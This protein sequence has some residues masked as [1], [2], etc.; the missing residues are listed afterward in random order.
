MMENT[1]LTGNTVR[2]T[3]TFKDNGGQLKDPNL[4]K[5]IFYNYRFEK[6]EEFVLG[7]ANKVSI[8]Q[9]FFDYTTPRDEMKIYYEFYGEI[10]GNPA[11]QRNGFK[12]K[13][14]I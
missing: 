10:A 8:G 4:I 14:I 6:I 5:V 9:Y 11:I 12:T 13:F 7:S 1:Y 3:A 2:L